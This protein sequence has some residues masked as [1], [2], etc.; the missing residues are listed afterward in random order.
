M[1]QLL[2]VE[3]DTRTT[4]SMVHTLHREGNA[5]RHVT[6]AQD[7]LAAVRTSQVEVVVL[8]ADLSDMDGLELCPR[9]RSEGYTGGILMLSAHGTELDRITG[10][11]SGADDYLVK[12]YGVGELLARVRAQ[13]R[14]GIRQGQV[15]VPA[16]SWHPLELDT[17]A[18]QARVGSTGLGLTAREFDLLAAL[19]RA[20][21]GVLT[22]PQL[23]EAVWGENWF[24]ST[25]MLDATLSRLRQKLEQAGAPAEVATVRGVG[26]R[27]ERQHPPIPG[28]QGASCPQ[29]PLQAAP[30]VALPARAAQHG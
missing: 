10:L 9:L 21:G 12:P 5:V 7:A 30:Q 6:T 11:D 17:G 29:R 2:L 8:D 28:Q 18:R 25:K 22:R 26:L 4:G 1:H 15:P 3:D 19:D 16:D 13:L 14:R 20:H 24:G 23:V 27:L